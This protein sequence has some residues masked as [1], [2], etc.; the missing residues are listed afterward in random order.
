MLLLVNKV[1]R[2]LTRSRNWYLRPAPLGCLPQYADT[3][4]LGVGG[5][6]NPDEPID[7]LKRD[8]GVDWGTE[9][10]IVRDGVEIGEDT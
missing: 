8:E 10:C 7:E 1:T 9:Y 4:G 2:S 5:N 6:D 3:T